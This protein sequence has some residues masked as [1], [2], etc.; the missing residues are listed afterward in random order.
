MT[1]FFCYYDLI[2]PEIQHELVNFKYKGSDASI[3]YSKVI[4]HFCQWL[5]DTFTP[6]WV[7]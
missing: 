3:I 1:S 4:T 6:A 5:N 7:A 2:S